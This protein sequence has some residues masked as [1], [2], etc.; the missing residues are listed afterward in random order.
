M[1]PVSVEPEARPEF[2][3]TLGGEHRCEWINGQLREKPPMGAR[4]NRVATILVSLLDSFATSR[5]LGLVF[6]Q[7]CGYQIF[8]DEPERVH[9]PDAS[10]IPHGRLPQDRPPRGHVL[11]AP[12]LVVEVVSPN[13]QAEEV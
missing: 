1:P 3:R 8:K 6:S 4:A 11:L 5:R 10:F 9:K 7:K 13:Y 2:R 12:D